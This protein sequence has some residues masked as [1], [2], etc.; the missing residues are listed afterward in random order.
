[1]RLRNLDGLICISVSV[2]GFL[3]VFIGLIVWF[4]HQYVGSL[5]CSCFVAVEMK[6]TKYFVR[7]GG[8]KQN[9]FI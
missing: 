8:R 7:N 5:K 6:I 3:S 1:M 9:S 4:E 2:P